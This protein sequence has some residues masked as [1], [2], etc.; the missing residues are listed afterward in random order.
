MMTPKNNSFSLAG[1]ELIVQ[2]KSA[3]P[4]DDCPPDVYRFE[5]AYGDANLCIRC[6]ALRIAGRSSLEAGIGPLVEGGVCEDC[7]NEG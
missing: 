2:N 1:G 3:S 5:F 7:G 4:G 6:G